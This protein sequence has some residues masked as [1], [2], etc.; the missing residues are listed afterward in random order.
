LAAR[1]PEEALSLVSRHPGPI[2]LLVS[3]V[4]L[5]GMNGKELK[6]RLEILRPSIRCL[7]ISGYTAD[8]IAH[9]GVLDEGIQFLQKPFPA[10]ELPRKARALLDAPRS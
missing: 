4:V 7:F 5:P 1:T 3:D 2:H 8:I 10:L 6:Q 9:H